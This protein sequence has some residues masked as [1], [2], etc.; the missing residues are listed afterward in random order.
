EPEAKAAEPEPQEPAAAGDPP[1]PEEP[2]A[3]L[4]PETRAL[5]AVLLVRQLVGQMVKE[6]LDYHLGKVA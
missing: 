4:S 3:G 5:A 1:P 6:Q 2:G